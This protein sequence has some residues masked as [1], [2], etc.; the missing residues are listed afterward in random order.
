M[1]NTTVGL[2]SFTCGLG[3]GAFGMYISMTKKFEEE[4]N[5]EIENIK[6]YYE[7][8]VKE[9]IAEEMKNL[10]VSVQPVIEEDKWELVAE[11]CDNDVIATEDFMARQILASDKVD[12]GKYAPST[13]PKK[14]SDKPDDIEEEPK[15]IEKDPCVIPKELFGAEAGYELITLYHFADGML[16]DC[17][18]E[19]A[20]MDVVASD[21]ADHFGEDPDDPDCVYVR[22]NR[23]RV[24]YEILKDLRTYEEVLREGPGNIE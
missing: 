17:Y 23:L 18:K 14:V 2:V 19:P 13:K 22:N 15:E 12:Y 9:M 4:L 1:N 11:Y 8:K 6:V 10:D 21:Y 16:A 5:A 24:F 7:D 3:I 20:N